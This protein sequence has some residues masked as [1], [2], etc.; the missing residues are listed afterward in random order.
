MTD[1]PT[2][3]DGLP[4]AMTGEHAFAPY[5]RILG[6]KLGY[7][8]AKDNAAVSQLLDREEKL[9]ALIVGLKKSNNLWK[10]V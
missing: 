7:I 5:L 3:L 9:S 6:E 2:S 4:M 10:R 8:P 1:S